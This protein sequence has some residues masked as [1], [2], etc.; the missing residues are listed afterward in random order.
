MM[1]P[2]MFHS[3]H[4]SDLASDFALIFKAIGDAFHGLTSAARFD[5]RRARQAPCETC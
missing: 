2:T 4:K 1:E 5:S 3:P